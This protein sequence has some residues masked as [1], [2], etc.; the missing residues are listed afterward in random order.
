MDNRKQNPL[1]IILIL[2]AKNNNLKAKLNDR[3]D[4]A[5]SSWESFKQNM[6][7]EMDEL[8]KSISEMAQKNMES[9]D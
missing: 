3:K 6:N 1:I 8:G 9:K 4:N 2:K 5:Q 7:E